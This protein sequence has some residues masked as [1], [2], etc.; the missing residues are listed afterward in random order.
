MTEYYIYDNWQN[1]QTTIHKSDCSFCNFGKG[2]RASSN[3][4]GVWRGPLACK[5]AVQLEAQFSGGQIR[6]CGFCNP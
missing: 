5:E 1:K 2:T 6:D 4:N 3:D